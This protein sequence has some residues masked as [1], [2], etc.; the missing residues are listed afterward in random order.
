MAINSLC[1]D[2]RPSFVGLSLEQGELNVM[3]NKTTEIIPLVKDV[4][5]RE[6]ILV[7]G[8][9]EKNTTEAMKTWGSR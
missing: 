6:E 1:I 3:I 8:F 7:S 9:Q 4:V 5:Y 2:K